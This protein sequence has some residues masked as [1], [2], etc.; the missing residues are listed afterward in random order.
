MVASTTVAGFDV[1]CTDP[2][3][4]ATSL[5]GTV[6]DGTPGAPG[7]PGAQG[8]KGDKGDPGTGGDGGG[9]NGCSVVDAGEHYA[10]TCNGETHLIAKALCGD[11][12]EFD[13]ETQFCALENGSYVVLERALFGW[14]NG[15][16]YLKS[17]MTGRVCT[18]GEGNGENGMLHAWEVAYCGPDQTPYRYANKFCSAQGTVTYRCGTAGVDS[19]SDPAG[20]YGAGEFCAAAY[21]VLPTNYEEDAAWSPN[22][23]NILGNQLTA[24]SYLTGKI[25]TTTG[26][27]RCVSQVTGVVGGGPS[28]YAYCDDYSGELSAWEKC[29]NASTTAV[30]GYDGMY[31]EDRQGCF[32]NEVI[33]TKSTQV[34]CDGNLEARA[35][36]DC[37]GD[38]WFAKGT[39]DGRIDCSREVDGGQGLADPATEFCRMYSTVKNVGTKIRC[40]SK[41]GNWETEFCL[42]A[43]NLV[44]G[45]RGELQERCGEPRTTAFT[46]TSTE[47]REAYEADQTG[48]EGEW[49]MKTEFCI[50]LVSDAILASGSGAVSESRTPPAPARDYEK[51][52]LCD[53]DGDKVAYAR[54]QWC[55]G[56][57]RQGLYELS[58]E[59]LFGDGKLEIYT[60]GG[61]A[62]TNPTGTGGIRQNWTDATLTTAL[63]AG[64]SATPYSCR[65][66]AGDAT[67]CNGLSATD[68]YRETLTSADDAW[69]VCRTSTEV[70]TPQTFPNALTIRDAGG[71][72]Q[73][74]N[75]KTIARGFTPETVTGRA[76]C[77]EP[78]QGFGASWNEA[79]FKC[80]LDFARDTATGTGCGSIRTIARCIAND[81][82]DKI[83]VG[84]DAC[85]WNDTTGTCGDS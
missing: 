65:A 52:E 14:C 6:Q 11:G 50:S 39:L 78:W 67:S 45:S 55:T 21:F 27:V 72:N 30:A 53:P 62:L 25:L 42:S 23:I 3:T 79:E 54:N 63:A 75:A 85:E 15:G 82:T 37:I 48:T 84:A 81:D 12:E 60:I 59:D 74:A 51:R 76:D 29:P 58:V 19:P 35:E 28:P 70:N 38:K 33:Y 26:N 17:A 49:D 68:S 34:E 36:G 5:L 4:G 1:L 2:A 43:T 8:P 46:G 32:D 66:C 47:I 20:V 56:D 69:I 83:V 16:A 9:G 22:L 71:L 61:V 44:D 64:T 13:P 10:I 31:R 18:P 77:G 80:A 40:G 73:T 24:A 7:A 41:L 57:G